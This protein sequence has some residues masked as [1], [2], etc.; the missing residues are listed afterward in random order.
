MQYLC[1][2]PYPLE[3]HTTEAKRILGGLDKRLAGQDYLVG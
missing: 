1:D 3:R 2:H